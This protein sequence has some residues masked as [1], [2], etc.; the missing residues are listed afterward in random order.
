MLCLVSAMQRITK[1]RHYNNP[2]DKKRECARGWR[3]GF[4]V[5][6]TPIASLSKNLA[7]L[8]LDFVSFK[9]DRGD[10]HP[11]YENPGCNVRSTLTP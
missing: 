7:T 6:L 11:T 1:S 8:L 9:K 10:M 2:P 5:T 4:A 3:N